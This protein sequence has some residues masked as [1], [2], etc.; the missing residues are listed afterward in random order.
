MPALRGLVDGQKMRRYDRNLSLL[1][2]E[3]GGGQ[4]GPQNYQTSQMF[5]AISIARLLLIYIFWLWMAYNNASFFTS[6]RKHRDN[7]FYAA[8]YSLS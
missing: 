7:I 6:E 3:L 1:L 4:I 8:K 5:F 2:L